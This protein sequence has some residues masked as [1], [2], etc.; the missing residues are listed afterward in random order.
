MKTFGILSKLGAVSALLGLT[1]SSTV[2]APEAGKAEVLSVSG[3]AMVGNDAAKV[4]AAI[5][6]GVVLSTGVDSRLDVYAGDNGPYIYLLADSRLTVDEL[7]VDRSGAETV[8]N[9]KLGLKQGRVAGEVKKTSDRSSYK[10]ETPTSTA[11]IRSSRYLVSVDGAVHV[12]DGCI[13]VAFRG[14]NYNVCKGQ[15]FDPTI[16]GVTD[17]VIQWP[18]PS[19]GVDLGRQL[20]PVG[21]ATPLSPIAPGGLRGTR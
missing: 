18:V 16:P 5:P 6:Q 12:Y 7:T 14:V 21:P 3:T 13:N 15:M 4:G 2:A 20:Q 1:L 11:S 17:S 8:I 9:T 10:V 19:T